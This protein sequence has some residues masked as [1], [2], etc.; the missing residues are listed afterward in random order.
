MLKWGWVEV[1]H[2]LY[3]PRTVPSVSMEIRKVVVEEGKPAI[4]LPEELPDE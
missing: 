4:I 2:D 3:F 1:E